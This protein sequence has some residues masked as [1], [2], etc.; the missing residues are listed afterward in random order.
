MLKNIFIVFILML[1]FISCSS[2]K[3]NRVVIF[4]S[5]E[6]FRNEHISAR[7]KEQFPSYEIMLQYI[8]TG[9]NA[10]KLKAEGAKTECDIVIGLESAY[11]E[12]IQD[13]LTTLSEYD[14]S[15]FLDE[16]V[17]AHKKYLPWEKQSGA[18]MINAQLL[19]EKAL[20]VP[21]SY[22]DLLKPEYKNL[23]AMPNPKSSGTG[24]FFVKNLVNV[25]GEE[26]A[27]SYFDALA[28]NV[29]Q[30][31]SSGSGPVNMLVQGEIPIGLGLAFQAVNQINQ[32][33][34]LDILYFAEGSPYS[35][36]GM[37]IVTGKETKPAVKEVFDFIYS[38]LV[39]EDKELFSPEQ[40]FK[41]QVN[42]IPNYPQNI[43]YADM[44]GI[45]DI[46]EK[47]Y[48]LEKWKY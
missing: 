18:I 13:V 22:Q 42:N 45:S 11:M 6:D 31:T 9:N 48:L 8:P 33:V 30:F 12:N 4:S 1:S 40:I 39:H 5:S 20:P 47:E 34:D 35:V 38:T 46:S 44:T 23:I 36:T 17:P 21:A 24:Y 3:D 41:N 7:L 19:Q 15:V 29:L 14:S 26:A 25:M 2:K 43:H 37:G 16:L 27:F 32:G 28:E 10:A